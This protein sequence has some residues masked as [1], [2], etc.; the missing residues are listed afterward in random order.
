[1]DEPDRVLFILEEQ[2]L[3]VAARNGTAERPG[4]LDGENRGMFAG[5][6]FDSEALQ[7]VEKVLTAGGHRASGRPQFHGEVLLAFVSRLRNKTLHLA[8]Q[9]GVMTRA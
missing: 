4:L 5:H 3:A 6:R 7:S 1:D 9:A 8:G 2:V